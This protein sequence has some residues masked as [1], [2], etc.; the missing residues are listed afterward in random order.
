MIVIRRLSLITHSQVYSQVGVSC[1]VDYLRFLAC[2]NIKPLLIELLIVESAPPKYFEL[3][4]FKTMQADD[5]NC[6]WLGYY[7][8][9]KRMYCLE[10]NYH[11]NYRSYVERYQADQKVYESPSGFVKSPQVR[12]EQPWKK[13]SRYRQP[14]TLS[15]QFGSY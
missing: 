8:E 12:K 5:Q 1:R 14:C 3:I 15:V 4:P 13:N 2:N 11:P 7:G 6:N 10:I 9:R